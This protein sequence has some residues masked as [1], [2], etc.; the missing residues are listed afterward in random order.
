ML[1]L[2]V[3]TLELRYLPPLLVLASAVTYGALPPKATLADV[4]FHTIKP[5]WLGPPP[6]SLV[7]VILSV[8]SA[9]KGIVLDVVSKCDSVFL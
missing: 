8:V 2:L 3:I 5:T 4:T 9:I 1:F 7:A 6:Y